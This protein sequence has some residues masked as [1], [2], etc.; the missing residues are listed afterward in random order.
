MCRNKNKLFKPLR[1]LFI[2]VV[3]HINSIFKVTHYH[4]IVRFLFFQK[5]ITEKTIMNDNEVDKFQNFNQIE[6]RAACKILCVCV[7]C[8]CDLYKIVSPCDGVVF[9]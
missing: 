9:T 5:P 4:N 2:R 6:Y 3:T 8:A 7:F 1:V